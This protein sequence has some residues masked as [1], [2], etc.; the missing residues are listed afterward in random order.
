MKLFMVFLHFLEPF[1]NF[2]E[3]EEGCSS[4]CFEWLWK[5]P[6]LNPPGKGIFM[7]IESFTK[8]ASCN[9]IKEF[10]H[11]ISPCKLIVIRGFAS[12]FMSSGSLCTPLCAFF[13]Y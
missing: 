10:V 3:R 5:V 11:A 13:G 8:F 2:I 1:V 6:M 7:N 4:R 12:L 9:N